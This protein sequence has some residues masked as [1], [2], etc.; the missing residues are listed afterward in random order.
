[1]KRA[2][3]LYDMVVVGV[4]NETHPNGVF[5]PETLGKVHELTEFAKTLRWPDDSSPTA[6]AV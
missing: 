1:M 5:N 4:V 6:W 2:F 3:S